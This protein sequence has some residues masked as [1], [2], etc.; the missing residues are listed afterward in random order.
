[1]TTNQLANLLEFYLFLKD[2]IRDGGAKKNLSAYFRYIGLAPD[3][4]KALVS[5]SDT[6]KYVKMCKMG[7]IETDVYC[8]ILSF[9]KD[10]KIVDITEIVGSFVKNIGNLEM[11]KNNKFDMSV[12]AQELIDKNPKMIELFTNLNN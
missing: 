6:L 8:S 3:A 11:I 12:K 7:T 10:V 1:M 5:D 4:N 9:Y 2:N